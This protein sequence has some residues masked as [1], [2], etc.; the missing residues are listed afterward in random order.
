MISR[1]R[2]ALITGV[3]R[4]RGIGAAIAA[5]L[6]RDGVR[7]VLH[8]WEKYD[9]ERP[10]GADPDGPDG[11]VADLRAAGADVTGVS[12]DFAD[13]AAPAAVLA[14][15]GGPVDILV[16][17]HCRAHR[18]SLAELTAAEIDTSYAVNTRS[19]LLLVQ[20]M[21]AAGRPG[22]VVLFT[23]GQYH[24]AMPEEIPYIASKAALH[25]LT[26]TL[27]IALARQGI[28]VNCVNP[29]PTDTG[30]VDPGIVARSSP[31]LP[32]GRWSAPADTAKLV[33]WLVSDE[34]DWVT[35]QVI[36]SDGGFSARNG[37]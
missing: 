8:S 20:G 1:G 19:T 12:A 5:R 28:T 31:D 35:G 36:A 18:Q 27:A 29:G 22:R 2:T 24:G 10:G 34:A 14:A 7:L 32:G 16:A 37:I 23:S 33:A 13:P 26:P 30:Q 21:A 11:I 25:E 3:G 17:N 9:T 4:R 15:A 6:A